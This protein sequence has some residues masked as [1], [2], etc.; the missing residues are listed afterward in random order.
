MQG[1][2]GSPGPPILSYLGQLTGRQALAFC[3]CRIL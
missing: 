2:V 3:C 1:G